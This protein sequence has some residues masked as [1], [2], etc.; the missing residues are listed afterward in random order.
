VAVTEPTGNGYVTVY[1]DGTS[2]P[3]ASNLNYVKGETVSNLV[4]APVGPDGNVVLAASHAS[5]HLVADVEGY[6]TVGGSKKGTLS[7][8]GPTR[9]LDTRSKVGVSTTIPVPAGG[10]VRLQ[11]AGVAGIPTGVS[12]VVLNVTVTQPARNGYVTVYAD[13]TAKPN[14][15]NLNYVTNQTVPNLVFAPV[16]SDGKVDLWTASSTHVI[17]DVAGYVR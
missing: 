16:G 4:L 13:G 3:N 12:A 17:A 7:P 15:S 2:K 5:T 1:P 10:A 11:V 14:S 6:Y 8:I 9:L